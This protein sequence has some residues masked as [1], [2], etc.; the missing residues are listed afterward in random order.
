MHVLWTIKNHW[1]QLRVKKPGILYVVIAVIWHMAFHTT[2]PRIMRFVKE[3][4]SL[5]YHNALIYRYVLHYLFK[6]LCL[7]Y[8]YDGNGLW[9]YTEKGCM[10]FL[11]Y[12]L[13]LVIYKFCC[14]EYSTIRSLLEFIMLLKHFPRYKVIYKEF[15]MDINMKFPSVILFK[16]NLIILWAILILWKLWYVWSDTFYW[17]VCFMSS[18]NERIELEKSMSWL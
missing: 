8:D 12:Q 6:K 5:G 11:S 13:Y 18:L 3:A 14:L 10:W 15:G 9:K 2:C 7:L 16:R 17:G 4:E 1:K